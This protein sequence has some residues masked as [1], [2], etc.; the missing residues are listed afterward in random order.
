MQAQVKLV[1]PVPYYT[2]AKCAVFEI[3]FLFLSM[4]SADVNLECLC[5]IQCPHTDCMIGDVNLFLN[6][7][8]DSSVAEID[9]MIA[10]IHFSLIIIISS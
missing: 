5:T 7:S 4:A 9:I 6:D 10:G 2:L 8:E 1:S 3:M